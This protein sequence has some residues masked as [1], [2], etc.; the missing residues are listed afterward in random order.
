M[1]PSFVVGVSRSGTTYLHHLFNTHPRIRLSYEGHLFNEG[2]EI[3]RRY[4]DLTKRK[5]FEQL[6][7]ELVRCDANEPLNNWIGNSVPDSVDELFE[8]HLK[9]P[10]FTGLIENIYQLPGPVDCW[11]NK[12]LRVELSE[13]ILKHWPKAKFVILIRD[14]RAV[15]ASQKKFFPERRLKYSA[16]YWNIHTA[17][18]NEGYIPREQYLLF[19]YED[20]VQN[21]NECL[22]QTLEFLGLSSQEDMV[23]LMLEAQPASAR[24]LQKW[25]SSLSDEE[26][27]MIESIC[28]DEMK[29]YG[30][31]PELAKSG[32]QLGTLTKAVET[33]LDKKS[34]IPWN[35]LVW[36]RKNLIK[37]Y[38]M[39]I[40]K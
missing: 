2:W 24:S 6:I 26:I 23:K 8:R 34:N 30:Y 10:S 5:Q 33:F 16:I 40:R 4:Q 38:W 18:I 25:R 32:I 3:Y 14:P 31:E 28:F 27:H 13:G 19:R 35:P 37:R 1:D 29:N 20:F 11:G 12:T 21:A 17:S 22:G 15:F 9:N 7:D 39:T 36:R